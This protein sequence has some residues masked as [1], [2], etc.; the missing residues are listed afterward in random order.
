L[1]TVGRLK[2]AL[3]EPAAVITHQTD[4]NWSV[5]CDLPELSAQLAIG[6]LDKPGCTIEKGEKV[7]FPPL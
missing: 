4:L 7:V 2:E 6:D 3:D 5:V 1:K